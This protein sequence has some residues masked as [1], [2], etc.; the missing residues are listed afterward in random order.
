[1]TKY[2]EIVQHR[3]LDISSSKCGLKGGM[4]GLKGLI[5]ASWSTELR[6]LQ[7]CALLKDTQVS[8]D[9]STAVSE[10]ETTA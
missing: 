3:L 1:M 7:E 4:L 10:T 8:Y 2:L 9:G 5:I 6:L